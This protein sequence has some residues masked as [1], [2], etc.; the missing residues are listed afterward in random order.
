MTEIKFSE[1]G[2]K[3]K[4]PLIGWVCTYTPEEII[5]AAGFHPF[6]LNENNPSTKLADTYLHHNLCPYVR[7]YLD[8]GLRMEEKQLKGI[9]IVNSCD[10]LRSLYHIW[11]KYVSSCSFVHFI[12]LPRI[13]SPLAVD[14]FKQEIQKLII[15][16]ESHIGRKI[17]ESDIA[18]AIDIYN[19]SR[20]LMRELYELRKS[21][22]LGLKGTSVFKILQASQRMF[23]RFLIKSLK[24]LLKR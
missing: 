6:R 7:I 8:M 9:V 23:K 17:K 16:L 15:A 2:P 22:H 13:T 3:P 14:Y 24:N 19:K 10:A 4:L 12:N 11:R 20:D 1:Q 5:Y 21:E 18:E